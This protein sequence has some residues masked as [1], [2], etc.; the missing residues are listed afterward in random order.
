MSSSN[1]TVAGHSDD[2][3]EVFAGESLVKS[4]WD[5]T[6]TSDGYG[7]ERVAVDAKVVELHPRVEFEKTNTSKGIVNTEQLE[8][9]D[10]EVTLGL[11]DHSGGGVDIEM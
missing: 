4:C 8:S 3:L 6:V 1:R 9:V 2:E 5:A 11:S 7:S 10:V